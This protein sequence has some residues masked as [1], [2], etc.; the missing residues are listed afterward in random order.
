MLKQVVQEGQLSAWL[1][2]TGIMITGLM[3]WPENKIQ[4]CLNSLKRK[5]I[6]SNVNNYVNTNKC[7][8]RIHKIILF[9][10]LYQS[11]ICKYVKHLIFKDEMHPW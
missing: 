3:P 10:S 1:I 11:Y 2:H 7:R 4:H 9:I 5:I 8:R 6:L